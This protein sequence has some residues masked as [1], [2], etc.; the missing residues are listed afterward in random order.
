MFVYIYIHISTQFFD[1]I[2]CCTPP[3]PTPIIYRPLR[4]SFT[5]GPRRLEK[6]LVLWRCFSTRGQKPSCW[7]ESSWVPCGGFCLKQYCPLPI[8]MACDGR[9][10]PFGLNV[11]ALSQHSWN[12]R[13]H[14]S[15][16]VSG[17]ESTVVN[18]C[19]MSI[20]VNPTIH[21]NNA[22]AWLNSKDS[23]SWQSRIL[24]I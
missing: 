18:C 7:H 23:Q 19:C 8:M 17:A 14:G 1:T 9:I 13:A 3:P 5:C 12:S 16:P 10:P 2:A 21:Q 6:E 20:P 24:F 4:S 15:R 11:R 22:V